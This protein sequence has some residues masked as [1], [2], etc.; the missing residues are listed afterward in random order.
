MLQMLFTKARVSPRSFQKPLNSAKA[1]I[2]ALSERAGVVT[3][4]ARAF[5]AAR[6]CAWSVV[7]AGG[8]GV[9]KV[10]LTL[11]MNKNSSDLCG[12]LCDRD[13]EYQP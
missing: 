5:R 2:L 13:P 1:I 4:V 6:G 11:L 12:T 7:G 8:S 3:I 9:V 10:V